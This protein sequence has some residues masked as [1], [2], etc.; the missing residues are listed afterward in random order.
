[1]EK[2]VLNQS[3]NMDKIEELMTEANELEDVND[4]AWY[5]I[6]GEGSRWIIGAY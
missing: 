4:L 5:F 3:L 2:E 6:K 1:M